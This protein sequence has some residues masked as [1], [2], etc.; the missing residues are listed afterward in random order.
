VAVAVLSASVHLLRSIIGFNN[1]VEAQSA[2][3][4]S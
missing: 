3:F 1:T 2:F 4:Q